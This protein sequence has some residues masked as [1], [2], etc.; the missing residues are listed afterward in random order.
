[1]R[2]AQVEQNIRLIGMLGVIELEQAQIALQLPPRGGRVLIAHVVNDDI[3][4]AN[5]GGSALEGRQDLL[6]N[7]IAPAM[8]GTI[9]KQPH[10]IHHC[11]TP[12]LPRLHAQTFHD[13]GNVRER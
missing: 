10:M 11:P 3:G 6:V 12:R 1:M 4:P 8:L 13:V 9:A 5:V 2:P 7:A